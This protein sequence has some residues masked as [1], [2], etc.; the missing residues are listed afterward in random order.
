MDIASVNKKNI[1]YYD[2]NTEKT[3]KERLR[4]IKAQAKTEIA[5]YGRMGRELTEIYDAT[6]TRYDSVAPAPDR[7][8]YFERV[9]TLSGLADAIKSAGKKQSHAQ[10]IKRQCSIVM[11]EVTE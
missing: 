9:G 8:L 4:N 5:F 11:N 7:D 6:K 3:T 10:N 2:G 1:I